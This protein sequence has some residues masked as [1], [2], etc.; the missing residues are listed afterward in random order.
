MRDVSAE[1]RFELPEGIRLADNVPLV[2][3]KDYENYISR[4]RAW[5][6]YLGQQ[7]ERFGFAVKLRREELGQTQSKYVYL[8]LFLPG[9]HFW[10]SAIGK[11]APLFLGVAIQSVVVT[12]AAAAFALRERHRLGGAGRRR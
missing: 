6:R 10:T 9:L 2:T 11:D 3:V 5:P 8:L 4:L 1:L 7:I 12:L